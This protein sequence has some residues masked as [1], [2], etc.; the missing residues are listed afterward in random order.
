MDQQTSKKGRGTLC[1]IIGAACW[2]VSGACSE[3]FFNSYK[4]DS[5]W[6]TAIR[7][8][9]AGILLMAGTLAGRKMKLS[10]VLKDKK[11]CLQILLFSLAGLT[12]CQYAYLSAIQ[13]TNAGTAT[14]LQNLSIVFIAAY[15]CITTQTPPTKK[16][17]VCIILA[18]IGVW[19]IATGGRPGSMRITPTGLFWGITAGFSVACYS[20]LSRK[21]VKKW[22]SIPVTGLGML[23]GGCVLFISTQ[24][25]HIPADLDVRALIYLAVIV[26][27]GT[28]G[29][30]TLFMK[31]I[32]MVGPVKA[33]LL[34]CLE[35]LTATALSAFW[36]HTSF[37]VTDILGFACILT[38]VLLTA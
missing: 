34:A 1:C 33:S 4:I 29:A 17:T 19:L 30:F 11:G 18:L 9:T 7:M 6:V 21:P 14:V 35:P 3:A 32:S 24:A 12:L 5:A 22:G 16:V 13:W 28:V 2:G 26:L 25:W 8:L 38:T 27:V 10:A 20:L 23:I 37:S 36:L 31:G 15:V